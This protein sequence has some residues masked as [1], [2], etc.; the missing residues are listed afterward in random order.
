MRLISCFDIV[1]TSAKYITIIQKYKGWSGFLANFKV[2]E[3][4]LASSRGD[5][6]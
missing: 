4:F 1:I 5:V 3:D 2:P 6:I